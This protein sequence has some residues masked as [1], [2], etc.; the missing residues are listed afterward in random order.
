MKHMIMGIALIL[1]LSFATSTLQPAQAND[2]MLGTIIGA[3]GG[4][5]LGSTV[6]KGDGRIVATAAGTVIGAVIGR[7]IAT[8]NDPYYEERHPPKRKTVV[9]REREPKKVVFVEKKKPRY[10][11]WE[12]SA[13][14]GD[15]ILVCR[16]KGNH[17][18]WYD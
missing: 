10:K 3:V 9:Y 2:R 16:K 11:K 13:R 6:G 14:Y 5:L 8:D 17:C 18:Q 7:E 15:D 4:G 12:R 1:G